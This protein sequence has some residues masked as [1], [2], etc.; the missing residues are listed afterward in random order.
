[1]LAT[2]IVY[3]D[4]YQY[5]LISYV[6]FNFDCVEVVSVRRTFHFLVRLVI[7]TVSRWCTCNF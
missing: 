3:R 1:M 4:V 2:D 6:S 7:F 5:F